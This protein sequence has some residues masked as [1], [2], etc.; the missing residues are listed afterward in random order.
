MEYTL[1]HTL[2]EL[3]GCLLAKKLAMLLGRADA[4]A[5]RLQSCQPY[6]PLSLSATQLA[7]FFWAGG[8]GLP[9]SD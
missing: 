7:S 2:S 6:L 5:P 3:L 8:G 9:D 4:G 1:W